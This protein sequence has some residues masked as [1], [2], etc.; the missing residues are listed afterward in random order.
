MTSKMD[1]LYWLALMFCWTSSFSSA[2]SSDHARKDRAIVSME[3]STQY[4]M[5]K[6]IANQLL[7]APQIFEISAA[8]VSTPWKCSS[9][10]FTIVRKAIGTICFLE[11]FANPQTQTR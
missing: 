4:R 6:S 9:L 8:L 5:N 11:D 2:F 3:M 7:F 10:F 1:T